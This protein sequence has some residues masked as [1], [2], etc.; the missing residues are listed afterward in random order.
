MKLT[1][2]RLSIFLICLTLFL[3][4]TGLASAFQNISNNSK[5]DTIIIYRYGPDG[6]VIPVELNVNLERKNLKEIL[7]DKCKELLENDSQI[8]DFLS[9]VTFNFTAD[10]GYL[11]IKSQGRGFHF[12]TK[13]EVKILTKFKLFK[14]MIPRIK[15]KTNK[16]LIFCRYY[17]DERANTTIKPIIRNIM[18]KNATKYIEGNHTIFVRNFVGYTTWC[19]RFSFS[20]FDILPRTFVGFGRLVV[21]NKIG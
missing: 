21:C 11:F 6:S 8:Q 20:P 13:T 19:G 3:S 4:S 9:N 14:L 17:N 18:G 12:K 7:I 16:D 5:I 1:V 15:I 2:K 10:A